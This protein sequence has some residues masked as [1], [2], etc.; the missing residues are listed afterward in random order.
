MPVF[1]Y[2]YAYGFKEDVDRTHAIALQRKNGI[3]MKNYNNMYFP[4][5]ILF[6][7]A[8]QNCCTLR[9]VQA[10]NLKM[11]FQMLSAVFIFKSNWTPNFN[12]FWKLTFN[13]FVGGLEVLHVPR[14]HIDVR[15]HFQKDCRSKLFGDYDTV[16]T[17]PSLP[18]FFYSLD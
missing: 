10:V 12:L 2:K 18:V 7:G 4:N 6:E 8:V 13:N 16:K 15:F 9:I 11:L 1:M 3:R 5:E 17:G 14:P